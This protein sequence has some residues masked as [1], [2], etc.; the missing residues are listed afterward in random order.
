MADMLE[1]HVAA[2]Q[3]DPKDVEENK[4]LAALS[5]AWV[6]A[7][8][9]LFAK[10]KS[11][12]VHFHAKQGT[13]LFVLSLLFLMIPYANRVLELLV[14]AFMVW[15]FLAAAQGHWTELPFVGPLSRG[16]FRLRGS[17]KQTVSAIVNC[18]N[19]IRDL[20]SKHDST[21][22]TPPPVDPTPKP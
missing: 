13:V 5:Y 18:K 8:V 14:F 19:W 15:G 21:P 17:W 1:T 4:D 22:P 2:P 6:M 10:R 7:V 9:L 11:P 12:F 16:K 20:W 3:R